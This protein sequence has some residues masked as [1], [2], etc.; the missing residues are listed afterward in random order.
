MGVWIF[1][2]F[3]AA[4]DSSQSKIYTHIIYFHIF[5]LVSIAKQTI[6]NK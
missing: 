2:V 6:V 4:Y 5:G 3:V 1:S